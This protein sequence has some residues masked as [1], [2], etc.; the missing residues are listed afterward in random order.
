MGD[1]SRTIGQR[2]IE[3]ARKAAAIHLRQARLDAMQRIS[4]PARLPVL[5]PARV[6]AGRSFNT[7]PGRS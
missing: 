4:P 7:G 2:I 5:V 1:S 3:A 6:P